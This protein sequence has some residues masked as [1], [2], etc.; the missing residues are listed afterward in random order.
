MS[1][2]KVVSES[3][4]IMTEMIFP[5]DTNTLGNLMGGNLM[6]MMDVVGAIALS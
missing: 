2:T 6:R 1:K 3:L 4:T 5:N